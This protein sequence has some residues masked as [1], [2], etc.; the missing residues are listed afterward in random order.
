MLKVDEQT[1]WPPMYVYQKQVYQDLIEVVLEYLGE[2][3]HL[4]DVAM[5]KELSRDTVDDVEA[6]REKRKE[7]LL[8][9]FVAYIQVDLE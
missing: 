3:E 7:L 2:C 6:W 9:D 8:R 5:M 4:G 1:H